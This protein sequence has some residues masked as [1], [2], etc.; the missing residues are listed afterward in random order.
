MPG[1]EYYPDAQLSE[2]QLQAFNRRRKWDRRM[3]QLA[4]HVAQWSKDPSTKV[5]AVICRPDYT[6][7]SL[8]FNGFPRGCDDDPHM[9]A[10]RELKLE[11][12]VHA[13]MNAILGAREPLHGYSI[14]VWPHG[15]SPSCARCTAH[16][17]Q[18]GIVRAV[19]LRPYPD[20]TFSERWAESARIANAM[21]WEAG[22]DV[23]S[24]PSDYLE[25]D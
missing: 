4:E 15:P 6:V 9:Y 24:Y 3:L 25:A 19:H 16:I 22:V 14:F 20:D 10:D 21:Y 11:R 2:K 17:I 12:V 5:G 23:V 8:G 7:A 13:E 1:S 18:A